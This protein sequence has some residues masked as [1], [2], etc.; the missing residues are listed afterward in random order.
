MRSTS[1]NAGKI[2][3]NI[4]LDKLESTSDVMEEPIYLSPW[5]Y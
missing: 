3:F 4:I 5:L 1:K 2:M